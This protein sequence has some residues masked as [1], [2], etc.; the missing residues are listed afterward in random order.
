MNKLRVLRRGS[1]GNEV[2]I[3]QDL[4][5]ISVDGSFGPATDR[6]VRLYQS[7]NGLAV[8]GS[9]GPATWGKLL[10][11]EKPT[12]SKNTRYF[13]QGY[14]RVIACK[15]EDVSFIVANK[16]YNQVTSPNITNGTFFWAGKPNGILVNNGKTLWNDASH[17]WRGYGQ[18]ALYFDGKTLGVK[19]VKSASELGKVDWAIGGVT[20][21]GGEGYSPSSEGFNGKYA[22]VLRTT[23][24]TVIAVKGGEVH[25]LTFGSISHGS[26]L[27]HL[28]SYGY[29]LAVSLDGG[30]STSMRYGGKVKRTPTDKGR[31]IN[32]WVVIK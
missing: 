6:T 29:E 11:G 32:N 1:K 10:G 5:G 30:G 3:L 18:G 19:K 2:K 20:M 25:L 15:P 13:T 24:K 23:A 21:I 17:A 8:D 22:D 27:K 16:K 14:A 12:V 31:V 4:L 7:T 26:L 9:V 28:R